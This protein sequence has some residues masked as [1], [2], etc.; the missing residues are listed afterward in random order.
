MWMQYKSMHQP[1]DALRFCDEDPSNASPFEKRDDRYCCLIRPCSQTF[2]R[3][4][5]LFRHQEAYHHRRRAYWCSHYECERAAG[6]RA[7]PRKDKRNE[8]GRRV[9]GITLYS[10]NQGCTVVGLG[11]LSWTAMEP[12]RFQQAIDSVWDFNCLLSANTFVYTIDPC[13]GTN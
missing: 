4:A 7:F 11:F 9:H 6:G 2:D 12:E 8:H 13:L 10:M 1:Q 3:V 5:D